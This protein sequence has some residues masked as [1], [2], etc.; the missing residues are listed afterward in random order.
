MRGRSVQE[1]P[2][3]NERGIRDAVRRDLVCV[4]RGKCPLLSKLSIFVLCPRTVCPYLQLVIG[5]LFRF[6]LFLYRGQRSDEV[7]VSLLVFTDQEFRTI[8]LYV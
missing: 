6:Y 4:S 1:R 2:K 3:E 5:P 8:H 7:C